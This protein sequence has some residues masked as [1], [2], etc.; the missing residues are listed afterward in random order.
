MSHIQPTLK[1]GVGQSQGTGSTALLDSQYLFKGKLRAAATRA[2]FHDSA[3]VRWLG[4]REQAR[5][6]QARCEFSLL[7]VGLALKQYPELESCFTRIGL[8][9]NAAKVSASAHELNQLPPPQPGD[10][11][12]GLLAPQV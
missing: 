12:R 8:D 11:Q 3:D 9:V 6:Q 7:Y 10:A 4:G 2:K 1:Q 5:L